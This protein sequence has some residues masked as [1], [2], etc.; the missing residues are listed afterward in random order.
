M[1]FTKY[2][3]LENAQVLGIK[4]SNS[5]IRTASLDKFADF[6]DFRTEDGYLYAR[7]RA[8]SSRVNKNH[9]G[10]PSVELAGGDDIFNKIAGIKT[11]NFVVEADSN[12]EYGYS[13]FLGKPIFVDHHNSDPSKARGVIVDSKLHIEDHRTASELDPYYASAPD[14]HKPPTWVELLLEVDAKSFPKLAKAIIE[15][16]KDP[17]KGIDGFSMGCDVERSKCS[18]C[19]NEARTPDDYCEHVR[20]KGAEFPYTDPHTGKTSSKKSYEDCYG[21]KF[22]EI[23][24]VF[25]PADETALLR[26]VRA[27]TAA[28]NPEDMGHQHNPLYDQSGQIE[29]PTCGGVG[30]FQDQTCPGC[31]GTGQM[32]TNQR[33]VIPNPGG[34][35]YVTPSRLGPADMNLDALENPQAEGYGP[36]RQGNFQKGSPDAGDDSYFGGK[37]GS[38]KK[39]YDSM[40]KEYGKEKGEEV[41]Y[42]TRN[43]KKSTKTAEAPPPQVDELK[44]PEPVDTLREESI[45]P[46][47]GSDMDEETCEV[48]G[49]TRP[50]EGFDNP[51]LTKANP[52]LQDEQDENQA[53]PHEEE[54]DGSKPPEGDSTS[55]NPSFAHVTNDMSWKVSTTHESF[56]NPATETPVVPN[57]GPQTDEPKGSVVKQDHTKPVT[58]QVR[59]AEDFLAAT[60][61]RRT[62]PEKTADAAS[63]APEVATPDKNVDTDAV[64]GILDAT[65]E[66]ASKADAQI[67]V[68]G[69][70]TT[71]TSDVAADS[72]ETVDQGDEHSKNIEEI[73][74]K[75]FD[76]GSGVEKQRDPVGSDVYPAEG[77]VTSSW[78]VTALDSEPYPAEDGGLAGGSA[79]PGTQPA[80]PVGVAD[81]RVNVLDSTTSPENNSGETKTWSGTDGNGVYRQQEPVTNETL[82]GEDI[83]NLSPSTS[84]HIFAAFKVAEQEVDLGLISKDEKFERAAELEKLSPEELQAESR[85]VSRVKTAG[86]SKGAP[87]TA[88]RMPSLGRNAS[89]EKESSEESTDQS[90]D[91]ARLFL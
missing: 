86:L 87:K 31:Y 24:A 67:D 32:D 22:F 71:G 38:A 57:A 13:T 47:C 79:N 49:Y 25:D 83:V 27:H 21:I 2:A 84:S 65:N 10:W 73:P 68:E 17:S 35:G 80:D 64:G 3:S 76:N 43:K 12:A 9:D 41:Y 82:E 5:Q 59:T 55:N 72:T 78:Q 77:G 53:E 4:G 56:T 52:D 91:D 29:C 90:A 30:Q 51:D 19:D 42:A 8:I 37:P 44:M 60:G 39:A 70:G 48:C 7:I 63:G 74:T 16:S 50:P 69:V 62:M 18:H 88:K 85:V 45:C 66:E 75:T 81:E 23:S 14:N 15:G 34:E 36:R 6:E 40:I 28:G 1:A 20:L 26:E 58:S 61:T 46:V 89:V 54:F 11:A 33:G